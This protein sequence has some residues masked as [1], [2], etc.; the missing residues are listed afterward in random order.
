MQEQLQ[1]AFRGMDRPMG[2]EASITKYVAHLETFFDRIILCKLVV[3]RDP[4]HHHK[5]NRYRIRIDLLVPGREIVVRREPAMH[6]AHEDLHV[7]IHDAFDAARRELEDYI[8]EMRG[9][10]RARVEPGVV[11][12]VRYAAGEGGMVKGRHAGT[13][14][15][16]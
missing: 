15:Q 6:R 7:A 2:I 14:P 1:I 16:L 13:V 5:G 12:R 9:D 8:R 10:S 4:K 3:E 11:G